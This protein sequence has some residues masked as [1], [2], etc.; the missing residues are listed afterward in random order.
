MYASPLP[1]LLSVLGVLFTRRAIELEPD[2]ELYK[3]E[4]ETLEKVRSYIRDCL[5]AD[6]HA[7]SNQCMSYIVR[8]H[9]LG[10]QGGATRTDGS[11]CRCC[12]R[13]QAAVIRS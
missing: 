13:G 1:V 11:C 3:E 8:C 12:R 2:T 7:C 6:S 4:L 9:L 5:A 10:Y